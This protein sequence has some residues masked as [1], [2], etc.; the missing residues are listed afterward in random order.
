MRRILFILLLPP[1]AAC[2]PVREPDAP[3][4]T[5]GATPP[6]EVSWEERFRRAHGSVYDPRS[7]LDREKMAALRGEPT[8]PE[9][10]PVA[11]PAVRSPETIREAVLAA[12]RQL[13]GQRETHGPNRSPA[14][15][16]MNRITGVPMGSPYCASF[17]AWCYAAADAPPGWPRSAWSPDWVKAPGWTAA[18]GGETPQP[19]DAFGI[20]FASRGRVAHT[21][22]IE[23]WEGVSAVTIEGNTSPSAEFGA[24]SDRDGD[25]VWRKRRLA[26]QIH[27]VRNWL[28][29]GR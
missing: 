6:A 4:P 24:A 27:S 19:A 15:D 28:G 7:R 17:N 8:A 10:V 20:W 1:L 5:P 25:G 26:R 2:S 11:M 9:S 12:A 23:K 3:T 29:D 13:I 22:L 16:A 21:G 14:I 18:S